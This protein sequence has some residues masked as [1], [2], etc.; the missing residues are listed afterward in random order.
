[1]GGRRCNSRSFWFSD[2]QLFLLLLFLPLPLIHFL[3]LLPPL[4]CRLLLLFAGFL[5]RK[6]SFPLSFEFLMSFLFLSSLERVDSPSSTSSS[7]CDGGGGG[8]EEEEEVVGCLKI[9]D[10]CWSFLSGF[11]WECF[12]HCRILRDFLQDLFFFSRFF[13]GFFSGLLG[14]WPAILAFL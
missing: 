7:P 12:L 9:F 5:E 3:L 13:A 1:M 8:G 4:R 2:F 6:I 10:I 14:H 11:L